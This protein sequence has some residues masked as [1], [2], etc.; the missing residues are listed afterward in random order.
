MRK[1]LYLA[2]LS[3]CL[4]FTYSCVELPPSP[5]FERT[6]VAAG[7]LKHDEETH[8]IFVDTTHNIEAQEYPFEVIPGISNA[9]VTITSPIGI[10]QFFEDTT[11]YGVPGDYISKIPFTPGESYQ[12]RVGYEGFDTLE[13]DFKF[14]DSISILY[15]VDGDTIQVGRSFDVRWTC[16]AQATEYIFNIFP[17]PPCIYDAQTFYGIDREDTT[18]FIQDFG[19]RIKTDST[20]TL[21][22]CIANN[23]ITFKVSSR[24][25]YSSDDIING[26]G[27]LLLQFTDSVRVY[28]STDSILHQ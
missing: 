3:I 9:L 1:T 6:L 22:S 28:A 7:F 2:Y 14:P 5:S 12:L 8:S 13:L 11:Y 18:F 4:F 10:Y 27:E 21:R 16:A 25:R 17:N 23:W 26:Y 24:T 20:L 19:V 15:P